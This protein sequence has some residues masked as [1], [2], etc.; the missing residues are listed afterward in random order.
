MGPQPVGWVL[1]PTRVSGY[2]FNDWFEEIIRTKK[3]FRQAET[4]AKPN[5]IF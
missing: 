2:F 4:F 1:A 5:L 3:L